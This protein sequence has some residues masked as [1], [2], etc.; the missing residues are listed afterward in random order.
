MG[1]HCSSLSLQDAHKTAL[2]RGHMAAHDASLDLQEVAPSRSTRSAGCCAHSCG[3]ARLEALCD[4]AD[5]SARSLQQHMH[6]PGSVS[7]H[8][9][10]DCPHQLALPWGTWHL[11]SPDLAGEV[12][13]ILLFFFLMAPTQCCHT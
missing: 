5:C 8:A 3:C 13:M 4:T 6:I 2:T 10:E 7:T 11:I 9:Q 12:V 1:I